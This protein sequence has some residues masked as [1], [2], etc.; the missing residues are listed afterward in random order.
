MAA[1]RPTGDNVT[2]LP[3]KVHFS[4]V[5]ENENAVEAEPFV[6][7]IREGVVVTLTDPTALPVEQVAALTNPLGFLQY[8]GDAEAKAILKKLSSKEFGQVMKAYLEHFGIDT[9]AGKAGG[10]GF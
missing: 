1:R 5:A 6:A 10:L 4:L 3:T 7:E 9:E 2:E 8:T